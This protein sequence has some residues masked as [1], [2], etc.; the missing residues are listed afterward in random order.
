[1]TNIDGVDIHIEG[2]GPETIV[3]I[4][5]WPDTYR[6]WDGT[7]AALKDR[8]R[9]VRFT[10]PGFDRAH[11]RHV[12]TLEQL[13]GF[14]RQVVDA[15]SPSQPVTLLV[16]DWG[17]MIGY[18]FYGRHPERVARIVGVD[19]G[20][21]RS[22]GREAG[23]RTRTFILAYQLVLAM[24]W[25]MPAAL[26][27]PLTRRFARALGFREDIEP[28]G[29][30]MNYLYY[31]V[32]FGGPESLRR[33]ALAFNP[34][35]PTLYIYGRRKPAML[36]AQAWLDQLRARPGNAVVEFDTGHWVMTRAPERFHQ[37]V[38]DWLAQPAQSPGGAVA[39]G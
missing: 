20:D 28:V 5:G 15:V 23:A 4:H 36:H 35:C 33:Q 34:A 25:L 3:L 13:A 1:M 21:M 39:S 12:R 22:L 30:H 10:L 16:H 18:Q 19:V 17:C 26:G 32:W 31:N 38:R 24:A 37:V 11:P 8:Y 7:V 9:C 6:L 2:S 14:V 27:D 29:G